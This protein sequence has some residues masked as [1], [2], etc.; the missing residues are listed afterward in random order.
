MRCGRSTAA[1]E[2]ADEFGDPAAQGGEAGEQRLRVIVL[3][4]LVQAREHAISL[5]HPAQQDTVTCLNQDL[6][7]AEAE[8]VAAGLDPGRGLLD[9]G[10]GDLRVEGA[11]ERV[12]M[13]EIDGVALV[14]G[15]D[16]AAD[17][18]VAG[19]EVR[20]DL[21]ELAKA[22]GHRLLRGVVGLRRRRQNGTENARL[23]SRA[24]PKR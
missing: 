20:E 1:C 14:V 10:A 13:C 18:R 19:D 2:S 12:A 22:A 6:T 9:L 15:E 16:R 3:T 24:S 7:A 23:P 4:A 11:E 17:A 8:T 5:R 21:A